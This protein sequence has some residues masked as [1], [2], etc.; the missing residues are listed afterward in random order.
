[1]PALHNP[2][3]YHVCP[4]C[5]LQWTHNFC[6]RSRND[7]DENKD[8]CPAC[9]EKGYSD[10]MLGIAYVEISSWQ[11]K[12]EGSNLAEYVANVKMGRYKDE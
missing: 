8:C 9:H 5:G 12:D 6:T 2:E 7:L 10:S 3:Y 11:Y 1:M 4:I